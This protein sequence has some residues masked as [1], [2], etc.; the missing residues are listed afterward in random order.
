M[1]RWL[2]SWFNDRAF[3]AVRHPKWKAFRKKIIKDRPYCAICNTKWFLEAHHIKLFNEFP[4]LEFEKKNIIIL[5]RKHH[6]EWGHLFFFRRGN[7]DIIKD[8]ERIKNRP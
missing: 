7:P 8:I 5:C 6:F 4:E 3:G 1:I 2:K